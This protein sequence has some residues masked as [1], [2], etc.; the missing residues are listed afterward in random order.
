MA[1]HS[2]PSLSEPSHTFLFHP[3]THTCTWPAIIP[4]PGLWEFFCAGVRPYEE[5][6][7]FGLLCRP[8]RACYPRRGTAQPLSTLYVG[9][10]ACIDYCVVFMNGIT[11]LGLA[12]LGLAW[13]DLAWLGLTFPSLPLLSFPL[14]SL[15]PFQRNQQ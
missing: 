13:F 3:P 6:C 8:V 9:P 10:Y 2:I 12:W 5:L 14:P 1:L 4:T 7:L 15:P 11:E